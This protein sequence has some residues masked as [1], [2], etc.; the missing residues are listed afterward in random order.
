[1]GRSA[2]ENDNFGLTHIS[3]GVPAFSANAAKGATME[4]KWR[5]ECHDIAGATTIDKVP[6]CCPIANDPQR[7]PETLLNF[8]IHLHG[9]ML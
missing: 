1:M 7:T 8:L 3:D 6:G 5:T 4:R 9:K 2:H